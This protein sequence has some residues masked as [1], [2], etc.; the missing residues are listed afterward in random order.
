MLEKASLR[1]APGQ[2]RPFPFLLSV[3]GPS[4]KS[5]SLKVTYAT[6][7]APESLL[8]T[9]IFHKFLKRTVHSP[10]KFTYLHPGGI[11]S[12]A[13]LRA[14]SN[15]AICEVKDSNLPILLNLH[16]A[17]LEADS[18]QVRHMLDPVPDLHAWVLFPT[19]VT[20]WSSDDWRN[21]FS[22][23]NVLVSVLILSQT[24]GDLPMWR[25]PLEQFRT[26][27]RL[28][29]GNGLQWMLTSG[30]SVGIPM[31][32][33]LSSNVKMQALKLDRPRGMVCPYSST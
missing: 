3:Q 15:Q 11:V 29:D 1:L 31:G 19:G 2:S 25:Q 18:K 30:S 7:E 14:P 21:G 9:V 13:I 4:I 26:G 8:S 27:S 6:S 32:V 20:P 24:H 22:L 16:G 12:Y 28:M 10:H 33:G 23:C 5:L 17:G